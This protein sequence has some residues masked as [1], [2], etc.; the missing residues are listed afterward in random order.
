[1]EVR[2]REV[3]KRNAPTF[4]ENEPPAVHCIIDLLTAIPIH[5]TCFEPRCEPSEKMKRVLRFICVLHVTLGLN[6]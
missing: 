5:V 4:G 6:I 3:G 1:M 2:K